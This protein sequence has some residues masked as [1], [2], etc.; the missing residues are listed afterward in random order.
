M[1][2]EILL[3]GT[4]PKSP[5]MKN[6]LNQ[7]SETVGDIASIDLLSRVGRALADQTRC[8]ILVCLTDGAHYPSELAK[9]L[10]LTKA[11][12]SNHLSYLRT[13]GLVTFNREGRRARYELADT[14]LGHALGD[15]I[16]MSKTLV[17]VSQP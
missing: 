16:D 8:K 10:D 12:V 17:T 13:H 9:H 1:R 11:N 15:L 4:F 6:H 5:L 3:L 2:L 7:D 14:R